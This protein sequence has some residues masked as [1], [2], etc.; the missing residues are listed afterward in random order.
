VYRALADLAPVRRTVGRPVAGQVPPPPRAFARFGDGSWIVPS[1]EVH[2]PHRIAVGSRVIVLEH[3][4]LAVLDDGDGPALVLGDDVRLARFNTIVCGPGVVLGNG[5]ASSDQATILGSW[6]DV[7]RPAATLA[8]LPLPDDGPVVIGNGAYLGCNS[9][10]YPGVTIGDGAYIGEGAVVV[11]D[12]PAHA[13][14]SGNPAVV[15]RRCA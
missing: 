15:V 6:R 2:R 3:S 5:V 7:H 13:V 1:A 10:V 9:T 12:V 14:V 11:E 8:G 4:T